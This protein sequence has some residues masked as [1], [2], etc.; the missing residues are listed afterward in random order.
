MEFT[1]STN[2]LSATALG[3]FVIRPTIPGKLLLLQGF[4]FQL[5]F[6]LVPSAAK[7]PKLGCKRFRHMFSQLPVQTETKCQSSPTIE[8]NVIAWHVDSLESISLLEVT[9]AA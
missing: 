5:I 8:R 9:Q 7:F 2:C 1:M 4:R 3:S 6:V